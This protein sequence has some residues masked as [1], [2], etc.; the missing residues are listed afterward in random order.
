MRKGLITTDRIETLA[1]PSGGVLAWAGIGGTLS[2]GSTGSG[3]P[4]GVWQTAKDSD[5]YAQLY[6]DIS[7]VP[8]P[9]TVS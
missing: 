2:A 5:G 9:Q 1:T 6:V 7:A 3:T 4:I 8:N